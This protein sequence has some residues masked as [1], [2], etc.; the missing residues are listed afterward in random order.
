MP[1]FRCRNKRE[2]RIVVARDIRQA[3]Y[4]SKEYLDLPYAECQ[5]YEIQPR[6]KKPVGV[7]TKW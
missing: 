4:I 2:Q 6:K 3:E 1:W 5:P 7:K